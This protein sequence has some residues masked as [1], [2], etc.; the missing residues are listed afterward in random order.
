VSISIIAIGKTSQDYLN[1]GIAEFKKRL[2]RYCTIKLIEIP[3]IKGKYTNPLEIKEREAELILRLIK[4]SDQVVALDEQGVMKSSME[5]AVY[6]EDVLH[7]DLVFIA[8]GAH[9]LDKRILE[10]ANLVL[11]FSRFTF[12]HQM[13]RLLLYEQLYRSMNYL[14]GGQYHK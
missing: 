7:H 2:H 1:K 14:Q 4:N 9:G 12:T 8:G 11:S 10:R 13:I 5:F 6:L 3:E